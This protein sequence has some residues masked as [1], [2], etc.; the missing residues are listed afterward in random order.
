MNGI[1]FL[2]LVL[3]VA[4][5]IRSGCLVYAAGASRFVAILVGAI[6]GLG[7]QTVFYTLAGI[8]IATSTHNYYGT[9]RH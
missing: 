3:A 2:V 1:D 7:V 6:A 5:G 8:L 9:W 4:V